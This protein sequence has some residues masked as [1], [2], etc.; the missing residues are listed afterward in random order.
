M[1]RDHGE[2]ILTWLETGEVR[3]WTDVPLQQPTKDFATHFALCKILYHFNWMFT[4][5]VPIFTGSAPIL[6]QFVQNIC[7][8]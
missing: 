7:H 4:P 6:S 5:I 2:Y 1:Y 8:A 3:E